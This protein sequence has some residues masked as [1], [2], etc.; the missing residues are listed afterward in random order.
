MHGA[1]AKDQ[2]V[3]ADTSRIGGHE[4]N[5]PADAPEHTPPARTTLPMTARLFVPGTAANTMVPLSVSVPLAAAA[6]G[7]AGAAEM[8]SAM[9]AASSG[10][11]TSRV[12][13]PPITECAHVFLS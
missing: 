1:A 2:I 8:A 3:P 4:L 11:F 6:A 10:P 9:P 12:M 7:M 13:L 5:D